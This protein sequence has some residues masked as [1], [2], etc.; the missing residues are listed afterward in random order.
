VE[1]YG[2]GIHAVPFVTLSLALESHFHIQIEKNCQ[3]R[4]ESA[5]CILDQCA[6]LFNILL[7]AVALIGNRR[8]VITI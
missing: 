6:D 1:L 5:R 8:V 3:V 4:V 2:I 7:V